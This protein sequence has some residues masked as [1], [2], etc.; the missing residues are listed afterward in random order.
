M[1]KYCTV[2]YFLNL[3][4]TVK[5]LNYIYI[6]NCGVIYF[7]PVVHAQLA[8][9]PPKNRFFLFQQYFSL[10]Y[11]NKI[12]NILGLYSGKSNHIFWKYFKYKTNVP[13]KLLLSAVVWHLDFLHRKKDV[14]YFLNFK[15]HRLHR[16]HF[17]QPSQSSNMKSKNWKPSE[18]RII[19]TCRWNFWLFSI[20]K[21]Y[22]FFMAIL[23]YKCV[24]P[25]NEKLSCNIFTYI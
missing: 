16:H 4:E 23:L 15:C 7:R 25:C 3:T 13:G 5:V 1:K 21:S 2:S 19:F 14:H 9:F 10:R 20:F 17:K 24:V 6:I 18:S 12:F 11:F 8:S 22:K